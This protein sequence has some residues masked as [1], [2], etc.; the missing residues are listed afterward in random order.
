MTTARVRTWLDALLAGFL[1]CLGAWS[2]ATSPGCAAI[3]G[4]AA[5]A[6]TGYIAGHEAAKNEEEKHH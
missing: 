2:L 4:G 5:G 6:G 1:L 3:V